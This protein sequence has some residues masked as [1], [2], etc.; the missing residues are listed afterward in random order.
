MNVLPPSKAKKKVVAAAMGFG[1]VGWSECG[2]PHPVP[3]A[4][5]GCGDCDIALL[6]AIAKLTNGMYVIV[7]N[8]SELSTFFRRQV[9][10][11][12]AVIPL[13]MQ[14]LL[15]TKQSISYQWYRHGAD[16]LVY[17]HYRF[18][19][20]DLQP[21][22]HQVGFQYTYEIHIRNTHMYTSTQ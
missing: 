20:S 11:E 9:G 10:L 6:Q 15:F 13:P 16:S 7:G 5:V 17:P 3:I 12:A 2:L 8:I 22:S 18:F 14:T 21:N 1:P 19:S 4:C